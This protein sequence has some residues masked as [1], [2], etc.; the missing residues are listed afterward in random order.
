MTFQI[1]Q[2][3]TPLGSMWSTWTP[4]GLFR[5][6]WTQPANAN[7]P[8]ETYA[9]HDE[10]PSAA[11]QFNDRLQSFY[12]GQP[13]SFDDIKIDSTGW[14]D[15]THLVYR[16]CREIPIGTTVTYKQLAEL[17]E[18]PGASRAV[19]AAM[20][21]NRILLVIPCHRVIAA[22]GSLRGFSAPGGLETKQRLLDLEQNV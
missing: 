2:H 3:E 17:A 11:R 16:R 6:D 18:R 4:Q 20:S 10:A 22:D 5:L 12:R 14:T 9:S 21:R 19:G 8:A 7:A 1:T 13:E 15:F